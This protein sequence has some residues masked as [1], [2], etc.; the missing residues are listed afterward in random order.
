MSFKK[1]SRKKKL[2]TNHGVDFAE[3]IW[4]ESWTYIKTIVDTVREPFLVLDK[5]LCVIADNESFYNVFQVTEKDTENKLVYE[6]GNRQWD[7]PQLQK[8]LEDILPK[9]TYF[10]GF[11]VTH[12]FPIIGRKVMI[13]NARRVYP[14]PKS[15]YSFPPIILLAMEDITEMMEVA[16]MLAKHT[17]IFEKEMADRTALLESH[18]RELESKIDMHGIKL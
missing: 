16:E 9:N 17:S 8:L 15:G 13:L 2:S 18:I 4:N 6:L 14:D 1:I 11:E 12:D 3:K 5:N 7:I 10:K